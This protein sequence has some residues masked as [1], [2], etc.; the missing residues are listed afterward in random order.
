VPFAISDRFNYFPSL[1]H[2]YSVLQFSSVHLLCKS[3]WIQYTYPVTVNN[4]KRT[5]DKWS[6]RHS[7]SLIITS[8]MDFVLQ[9]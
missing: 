4:W 3:V 9:L 6:Q 5:D 8:D 1:Y 7:A 2:R